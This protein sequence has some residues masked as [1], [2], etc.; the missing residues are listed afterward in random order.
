MNNTD[1]A[2][3]LAAFREAAT[4]AGFTLYQAS[5]DDAAG[6]GYYF[7]YYYWNRHRDNNKPGEMGPMEFATVRNHVYKLSVTKISKI[8]YPRIQDNNPDPLDPED[9]D[10]DSELYISV[11]VEV[12]PWVVCENKIE[13]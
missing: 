6:L 10:E 9:P 13:F 2:D 11:A 5:K 12:L 4:A 3:A 7:Y 1:D 8:G